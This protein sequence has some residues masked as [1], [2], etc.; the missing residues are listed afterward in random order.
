[1]KVPLPPMIFLSCLLAGWWAGCVHPLPLGLEE[2]PWRAPAMVLTLMVSL[3]LPVWA[4]LTFRRHRTTPEPDGTPSAMVTSGPY[5][6]SRN[7][8]Y[9]GLVAMLS[10]FGLLL[11][12]LWLLILVPVLAIELDRLI[13]PGEE[14]RLRELFGSAYTEY[15]RKV[16]RW[17]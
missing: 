4:L 1:M 13:I 12:S 2:R 5:R 15:A 16:R 11:D 9:L 7:P 3:G 8:M 17:L 10:W 6:F 14:E